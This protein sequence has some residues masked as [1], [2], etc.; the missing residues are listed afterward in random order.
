MGSKLVTLTPTHGFS[1]ET[2]A[3]LIIEIASRFG[4]PL[5]TT[6]VISSTILGVGAS[7]R[8][9]AVRWNV[10]GGIFK[11]WLLTIPVCAF[12]SFGVYKLLVLTS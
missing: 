1:A 10:A 4:L 5:S 11:A 6:H 3:A 7:K 12:I 2:S 8:L 9:K